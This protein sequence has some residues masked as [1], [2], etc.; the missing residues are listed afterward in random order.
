MSKVVPPLVFVYDRE[1]SGD[2]DSPESRVRACRDYAKRMGWEV[3]GQWLEQ[4]DSENR[5]VWRGMVAAMEFQGK[6]R[7]SVC[8]VATWRRI[9]T[10]PNDRD[11]LRLS[12]LEAGGVC[13]AIPPSDL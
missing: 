13:I 10:D 2:T 7:T 5:L 12:V 3:A 8:L 4:G 6:D 11:T 9:G 1:I